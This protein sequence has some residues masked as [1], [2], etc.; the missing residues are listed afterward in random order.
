M[1]GYSYQGVF[2][3]KT[4]VRARGTNLPISTKVSVE[5]ASAIRG[6]KL[7]KAISLLQKV[8]EKKSAIAYKKH[9]KDVPHRKGHMAAGRYPV[10]ASKEILKLLNSAKSEAQSKGLDTTKLKIVHAAACKAPTVYHYGRRYCKRKNSHFELILK[11][12]SQ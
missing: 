8:I 7:E 2:D 10:K 6:K 4:M 3:P 5:I 9:R 1:K 12:E 11:E